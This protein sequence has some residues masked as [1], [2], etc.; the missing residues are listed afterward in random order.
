MKTFRQFF[1][2]NNGNRKLAICDVQPEYAKNISFDM[3]EFCKF[4]MSYPEVY[5]LY[6]GPDLGF[7]N[8]QSIGRWYNEFGV[9][10]KVLR[11]WK[12]FEK[13]Y[14]WFRDLMDQ[15]CWHKS[16]LVRLARY[17]I[18]QRKWDWRDLKKA[19]FAKLKIPDITIKLVHQYNF[20]IPDL[21]FR[22]KRL[23]GADI[24]G[25]GVNECLD[26]VMILAEAMH[27]QLNIINEWTYG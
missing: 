7:G 26:E 6:N 21:V 19:D 5:V 15:G 18:N 24:C 27:V 8:A 22:I 12:W 17:M 10:F 2:E 11:N 23:N 25:G 16:H 13:N 14:A 20:H 3:H 9:P 4:A 1:V